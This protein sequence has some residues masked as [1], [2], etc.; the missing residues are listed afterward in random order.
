M[1]PP[2]HLRTSGTNHPVI[3]HNIQKNRDLSHTTK[4]ASK[5]EVLMAVT[6][7]FTIF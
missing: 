7:K 4:K 6:I 3:G 2:C 5:Y 1:R